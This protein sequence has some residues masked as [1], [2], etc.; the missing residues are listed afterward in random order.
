MKPD[1]RPTRESQSL[2]KR[3]EKEPQEL[4]AK[5]SRLTTKQF[6]ML[7]LPFGA[8]LRYTLLSN[9][10]RRKFDNLARKILTAKGEEENERVE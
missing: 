6:R 10:E 9:Y 8:F 1:H 5:E 7:G 4:T 3:N 2:R